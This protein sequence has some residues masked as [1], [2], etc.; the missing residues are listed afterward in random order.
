MFVVK[1]LKIC[2]PEYLPDEEKYIEC[3]FK[4]SII[5]IIS[6]ILPNEKYTKTKK[7]NKCE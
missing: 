3:I 7:Q 2:S 1:A 4:C 5:P 6:Y